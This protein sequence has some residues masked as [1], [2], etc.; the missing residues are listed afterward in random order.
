M[1]DAT[2][3]STSRY[4][5]VLRKA[6]KTSLNLVSAAV[7]VSLSWTISSIERPTA[8]FRKIMAI[9][10]CD[11]SGEEQGCHSDNLTEEMAILPSSHKHKTKT[12]NKARSRYRTD[13]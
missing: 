2:I 13:K 7:H 3:N 12:L 5:V 1:K 6:C 9:E 8:V 10:L 11:I 4:T